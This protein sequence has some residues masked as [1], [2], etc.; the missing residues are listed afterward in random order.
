MVGGQ[1]T[2]PGT[3][4]LVVGAGPAGLTA[5]LQAHAH[6]ATVRVVDRR[7]HRVRP[8]RAMMLH[9]RAL[10]GLRPLGV[11]GEL[12]RRADTAPEARIHLGRRVVEG[13]LGHAELPDTAFPHLTLVRQADVEDVLWQALQARGVTVDWGV[14][15]SG[16]GRGSRDI[17]GGQVLADLRRAVGREQHVARFLA[18]CDG[19]SSTVRGVIG[20]KWRGGAYRV[21]AVLADVEL[22]GV[23]DPGVLHVAVGRAGLAFLFALGE[24][25]T[26]RLL[27]TRP[28]DL[29]ANAPFGQL[30][31]PVP[32]EDVA[33]L[34]R[35]SGLA[36]VVREVRWSAQIPLQH[37]LASTFG[38]DPIFLAGD[39]AHAHSPAGGQG[40]N[41]GILDSLNLGWKLGFASTAGRPLPELLGT[42]GQERRLAARRVL[43][44]TRIIFFGEAS[45]HAVARMARGLLPAFAPVLPLLLRQ[46]WLTS[47][48]IR[49]LA[50]PFVHYRSSAISRDGT[51]P[52]SRWPRP[53]ERLPDAMVSVEG[54]VGRLHDLTALPG[55]HL[56]LERDAGAATLGACQALAAAGHS[57]VHVHRLSSHPGRG[58][59]A[60]RPDGYVGFR[61]GEADPGQV[62]DWLRLV[63]GC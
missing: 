29:Q 12:L 19:Q 42:Y 14:E 50:Q 35:D 7:P 6:G 49:L 37:R 45:P 44:L 61:C 63:G 11:T 5:A 53:G 32:P 15:F 47:R 17:G 30:G 20:A 58:V 25:A 16:L 51:P 28:A 39:A 59:V 33:R 1:R 55:I 48:G 24:G 46:R 52:G 18:G 23:L 27:A 38:G 22:D 10:E 41:N 9:A 13:R 21:E 4:V 56:L 43:A 34:L 40:M 62:R 36:A 57:L 31:P 8:S 26:W 3:D 60:V 54:R 2:T